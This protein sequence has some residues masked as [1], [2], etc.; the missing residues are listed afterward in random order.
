MDYS[1]ISL[2]I[3]GFVAWFWFDSLRSREMAKTICKQTCQQLN[4][5]LLDDTIALARLRLRRNS[6][7]RLK[8]QRAYQ[9]E[10]SENGGNNRQ[11]G[12]V[13]LRGITLEILEMPGYLG[14]TMSPV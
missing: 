8:V 2:I 6:N 10:F 11:R 7:G 5:Q 9:F 4:L 1:I 3:L 12:M 14:R 13:I